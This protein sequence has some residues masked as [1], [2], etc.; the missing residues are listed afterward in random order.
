[1]YNFTKFTDYDSSLILTHANDSSRVW[2][3]RFGYLNFRYMQRISKTGV[4]KGLQ[5]IHFSEGVWEGCILGKNPK[6]NFE[7]REAT[8]ASYSLDIVHSDL[9][10]PF[11]HPSISKSRYVLTFIDDYS[12]YTWV[13]FLRKKSEVFE[14]KALSPQRLIKHTLK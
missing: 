6:E 11:P 7:N 12:C 10:G 2:H 13:Y 4:V 9:M 3:E 1:L 14:C 5:D 8:R